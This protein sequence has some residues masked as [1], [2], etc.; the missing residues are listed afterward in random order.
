MRKLSDDNKPNLYFQQIDTGHFE[1]KQAT[2]DLA[3]SFPFIISGGEITEYQ[4]FLGISK[5]TTYKFDVNDNY[6]GLES[7]YYDIFPE[8]IENNILSGNSEALIFCVFDWDTIYRGQ[9]KR[10]KHE[11]FLSKIDAIRVKFPNCKIVICPTMPSIEY[12]FLLHFTNT[13][14]LFV[15]CGK[16]N[17]R[18]SPLMKDF[19]FPNANISLGKIL[20]KGE[21]LSDLLWVQKL[22][23]DGKLE[24]AIQNAKANIKAAETAGDLDKHSYSYVY[25]VFKDYPQ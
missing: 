10:E 5:Y 12:W 23:A 13:D 9:T 1:E 2:R 11:A 19:C 6:F 15:S 14:D 17:N 7:K 4:Y 8:Y 25:Q 22:C 16:V 21:Y 18:L 24:T 3:P 20:K